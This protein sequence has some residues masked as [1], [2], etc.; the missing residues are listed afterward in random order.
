MI[1]F[2]KKHI[3]SS[4]EPHDVDDQESDDQQ[5]SKGLY[6]VVGIDDL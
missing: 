3:S 1:L 2:V 4:H 6:F 5:R